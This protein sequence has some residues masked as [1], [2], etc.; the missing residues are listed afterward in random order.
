MSE[1]EAQSFREEARDSF[2]KRLFRLYLR[3]AI[4]TKVFTPDQ[5]ALV[6]QVYA[7]DDLLDAV[8]FGL[9]AEHESDLVVIDA[10][11]RFPL[12]EKIIDAIINNPE[13]FIEFIRKII[14]LFL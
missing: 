8:Y 5:A 14:E 1:F 10:E 2:N 12:L 11:S 9:K 13:G 7:N 4:R 3:K 6:R